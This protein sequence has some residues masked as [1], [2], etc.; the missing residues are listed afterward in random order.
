MPPSFVR[1][2]AFRQA[3]AV[4]ADGQHQRAIGAGFAIHRHDQRHAGGM[5][6]FHRIDEDFAEDQRDRLH[7][8]GQ[9]QAI[10][11]VM[12]DA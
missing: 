8:P 5:G 3:D 4:I 7:M 10:G 6:I 12:L 2:E 11:A 1:I 9:H